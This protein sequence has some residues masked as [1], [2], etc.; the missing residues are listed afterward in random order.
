MNL[1]S[2]RDFR[3]GSTHVDV[4]TSDL[5]SA[6]APATLSWKIVKMARHSG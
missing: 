6:M 5:S 2:R 3:C 4:A 1:I